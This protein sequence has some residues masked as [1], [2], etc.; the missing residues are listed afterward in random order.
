MIWFRTNP[1]LLEPNLDPHP[2]PHFVVFWGWGEDEYFV[3]LRD[4]I[5]QNASVPFHTTQIK[6][7]KVPA[8]HAT[9][10]S[11]VLSAAIAALSSDLPGFV[12]SRT[13]NR[14]NDR[15]GTF[16]L[17]ASFI[18]PYRP[19]RGLGFFFFFKLLG[20]ILLGLYHKVHV[21]PMA[22]FSCPQLH[23]TY[24]P[25]LYAP[26]HVPPLS[27][28]PGLAG[29]NRHPLSL[30][31]ALSLEPLCGPELSCSI[32]CSSPQGLWA[33]GQEDGPAFPQR[34]L[35]VPL[36]GEEWPMARQRAIR[37][38]SS[39]CAVLLGRPQCWG[40]TRC[41]WMGSAGVP[42]AVAHGGGQKEGAY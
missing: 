1:V 38:E 33:L 20:R 13:S 29:G 18:R 28:D 16:F 23:C 24:H 37:T 6:T 27:G 4:S 12:C 15:A 11:K 14:W 31:D 5:E 41:P 8:L 17:P 10:P 42:S 9:P 35:S 21:H 19:H 2:L 39:C 25:L 32:H 7:Q 34:P 22:Y 30:P 40:V 3:K 26:C 36:P